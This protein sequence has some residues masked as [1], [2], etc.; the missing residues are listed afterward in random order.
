[1]SS[2][3]K[4]VAQV[5][6]GAVIGFAQT[7]N[8]IGAIIGAGLAFYVASSQEALSTGSLTNSEPSAQTVRSS[9]APIR[10]ILGR[11]S[12]GGV[13]VWAQE[14]SGNQADGE[15]VHLVYVLSE[16]AVDGLE[17]IMLGEESISTY[18]A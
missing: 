6:I 7:G 12:T 15:W 8:P 5:A 17:D 1:M 4:K 2:A 14:Q 18:G 10:F 16:G 13:L 11:A 3:V 9:K